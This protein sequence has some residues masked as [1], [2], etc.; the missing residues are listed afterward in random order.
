MQRYVFFTNRRRKACESLGHAYTLF[1]LCIFRTVLLCL[2][3]PY[4]HKKSGK[5]SLP[6]SYLSGRW[7]PEFYLNMRIP[8]LI[9][10]ELT[11]S[12]VEM[13][14]TLLSLLVYCPMRTL[15]GST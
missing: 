8:R 5:P 2:S 6:D 10:T 15:F 3:V 4:G 13:E 14:R 11:E 9:S 12:H 1:R 7:A